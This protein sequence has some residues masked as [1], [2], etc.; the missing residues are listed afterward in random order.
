[1]HQYDFRC[2]AC[3]HH[4]SIHART[5]AEYDSMSP[6]CPN[7]GSTLLARLINKVAIQKPSRDFTRLSSGE[8]LNVFESGDS[9]QVGQMFQQFGDEFGGASPQQ[10]VPYHD[11]AQ[12]LLR[13]ES[14]EKVERDLAASTPP[15]ATVPPASGTPK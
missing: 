6:A 3:Q 12:K 9:K 7:C 11:A 14:M 1:M 10:A 5:Y 15:P 2:K 8:M 13:G 4:F